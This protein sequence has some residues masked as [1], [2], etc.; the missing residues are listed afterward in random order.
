MLVSSV[1][2]TRYL[3]YIGNNSGEDYPEDFLLQ[4]YERIQKVC[5]YDTNHYNIINVA[6]PQE[7]FR[8]GQDHL[9]ELE[10]IQ[11]TITGADC[12][13]SYISSANMPPIHFVMFFYMAKTTML[14]VP[15]CYVLRHVV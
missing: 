6:I 13:V 12:P 2:V 9:S 5:N 7:P 15:V 3:Y 8:P 1:H 10:G 14:I 11:K 4:I